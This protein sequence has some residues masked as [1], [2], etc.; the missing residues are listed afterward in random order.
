MEL[1]SSR[2]RSAVWHK[3][4]GRC[5]YCGT[6]TNPFKSFCI[7]HVVSRRRGGSD[8]LANLVPCCR[9]CNIRKSDMTVEQFRQ[10]ISEYH[11]LATTREHAEY[12]RKRFG[13]GDYV[14][15]LVFYFETLDTSDKEKLKQ[16]ADRLFYF[17]DPTYLTKHDDVVWRRYERERGLRC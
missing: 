8:E 10:S 16:G 13:F 12:R 4:E 7:D 5:R 1:S 9:T 14:S 11:G 15:R 2:I 17:K 6:Q 3:T